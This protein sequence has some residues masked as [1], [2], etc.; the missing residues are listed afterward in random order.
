VT[1]VRD[2]LWMF[3]VEAGTNDTHYGIPLSRVTPVESCFYL[4]VPNTMVIVDAVRPIATDMYLR[5]MRPLD[6]IAWSIVD[7]GGV[8]GWANG[9]E[10]EVICDL[11]TRFPNLTGVYMD[12]FFNHNAKDGESGAIDLSG[13]EEVRRKIDMPHRRLDLWAVLYTHQVDGDIERQ[14]ELCDYV[15]YWTWHSAEIAD[16][17][18]N[19]AR[20]ESRGVPADKIS[21]GLYM[22]DYGGRKEL[23]VD[24]MKQQSLLALEWLKEGRVHNLAFLGSYLCDLDIPAVEWTREWVQT[25]KDIQLD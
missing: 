18:K 4:D 19:L 21:I 2:R 23:S 14:L 15:S 13:L 11:S 12:D 8:K 16:W 5:S 22:W 20:L 3:S 7:S 10:T 9:R 6:N 25:V 24:L 17:E 1:T